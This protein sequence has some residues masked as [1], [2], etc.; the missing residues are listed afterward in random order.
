VRGGSNC[1]CSQISSLSSERAA[2]GRCK[3]EREKGRKKKGFDEGPD[4]LNKMIR[5]DWV[6]VLSLKHLV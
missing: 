3:R 6:S 2:R 5:D 4:S 1:L